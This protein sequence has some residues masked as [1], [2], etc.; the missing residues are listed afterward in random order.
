MILIDTHVLIWLMNGEER[1]GLAARQLIAE[2]AVN[3]KV[4]VSAIT[5]WEIALLT[6]KGRI[7]LGRD[8]M[9]WIDAAL[10]MPGVMRAPIEPEIAVETVRLPAGLHNDPA[11]RFIVATARHHGWSL[12]TADA[13]LLAYGAAG[14]VKVVDARL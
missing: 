9:A 3:E 7:A 8:P 13:A 6:H 4:N 14:H 12:I 2:A 1:L 11:D 10:A 5:P